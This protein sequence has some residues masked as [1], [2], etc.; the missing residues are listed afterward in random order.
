MLTK[1]YKNIYW[2]GMICGLV[3]YFFLFG[4]PSHTYGGIA[5][6]IMGACGLWILNFAIQALKKL[7]GK[8]SFFPLISGLFVIIGGA[9][10]DV[11][12]TLIHSPDLAL[13]ANQ[14]IQFLFERGLSLEQ[15][16]YVSFVYQLI[17][18]AILSVLWANFLKAYPIIIQSIPSSANLWQTTVC[19]FAGPKAS[20][21]DFFIGK[22]DCF[23]FVSSVTPILTSLSLYRW[24][25][26]LEWLELVPLSR[27][28]VPSL[29][30]IVSLF[31][32]VTFLIKSK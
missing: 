27:L 32:T 21:F 28:F 30:C 8:I 13:E 5:L 10:F 25:L 23:Y 12:N 22:V 24:Y 9:I 26:G 7:P 11:V 20:N 14:I 6:I 4:K 18:V 16:Y 31:F 17:H 3:A 19:I 29:I 15:I 2:P 1:T